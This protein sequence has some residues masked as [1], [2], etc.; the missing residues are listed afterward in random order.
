[1]ELLWYNTRSGWK[2]FQVGWEPE[3]EIYCDRQEALDL[4]ANSDVVVFCGG[5]SQATEG[6]GRDRDF[7]MDSSIEDLLTD[8][9]DANEH[10]IVV[11]TAGGNVTCVDG[12]TG[13]R[14]S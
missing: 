3:A 11:L 10:T 2:T 12:P 6:E 5:H 7:A 8:V 14:A 1:V 9:L 4:A 13:P